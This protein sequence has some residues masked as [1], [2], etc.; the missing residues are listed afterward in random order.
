[1]YAIHFVGILISLARITNLNQVNHTSETG[2]GR[3]RTWRRC[4]RECPAS[5]G[6]SEHFQNFVAG[7]ELPARVCLYQRERLSM[8]IGVISGGTRLFD[9][10]A[11]DH[12]PIINGNSFESFKS[13][14]SGID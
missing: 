3:W 14:H 13:I 4:S 2:D 8:I 9:V 11:Y 10:V 5:K 12:G 7:S 1:M 6:I